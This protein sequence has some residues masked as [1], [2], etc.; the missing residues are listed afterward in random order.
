VRVLIIKAGT[1]SGPRDRLGDY[2]A[3]FSDLVRDAGGDPFVWQPREEPP[4]A[5]DPA[6]VVMSGS[7][8]SMTEIE[9]WIDRLSGY[10]RALAERGVP[11]LGVCFGHQLL[12]QS[13][14]GR[15]EKHPAGREVGTVSLE[16][17]SAGREDPLFDGVP[18]PF[19]ANATHRDH[20]RHLPPGAT[21]LAHNELVPVQAFAVGGN[22][23]GVQFHPEYTLE[24]LQ[25]YTEANR[26]F[27][28][29]ESGPGTPERVL[30][31]AQDTPQARRIVGNF[32]R[33]FVLEGA[34]RR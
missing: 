6:G 16:L 24:V 14:G 22:M 18:T 26:A 1:Y 28:E 12:A 20:V 9:P 27:L 5:E 15:V 13:L 34:G 2:D 7:S 29:G 21:V 10:V 23:R 33:H 32:V 25:A 3:W 4:P 30:R 11:A 31:A 17:T 19:I 8:A